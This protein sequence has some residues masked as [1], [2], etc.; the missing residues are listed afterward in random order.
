M[1]L[2]PVVRPPIVA[3]IA[4][5]IAQGGSEFIILTQLPSR[6]LAQAFHL[7]RT[8]KEIPYRERVQ[9]AK[10]TAISAVIPCLALAGLNAYNIWVEHWEHWEH[11]PPLEER[12][13][14]PYQNIRVKNFPWGDGDKVSTRLCLL[15]SMADL[16]YAD[17]FVSSFLFC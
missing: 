17:C 12:V 2:P 15:D 13:E 8:P 1:L 7:V 16:R 6:P 11:M 4:S 14:Y 10:L 5:N 3:L 9:C